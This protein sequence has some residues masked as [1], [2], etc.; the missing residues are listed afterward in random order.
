MGRLLDV[1]GKTVERLEAE[2]RPPAAA[3]ARLAQ[4]QEIVGLGLVVFTADGFARFVATPAP[5]F[6][7]LTALQLVERGEAERV[8]AALAALYEGVPA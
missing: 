1:T 6:G 3:A 7:G 2:G 8:V 5:L 4:V